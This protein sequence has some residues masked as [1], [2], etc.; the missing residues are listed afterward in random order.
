MPLMIKK[1][2]SGA[3]V[4]FAKRDGL[5]TWIKGGKM[6]MKINLGGFEQ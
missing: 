5:K 1:L 2:I 4:N 6:Q 3:K